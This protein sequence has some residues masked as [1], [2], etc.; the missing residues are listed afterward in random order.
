MGVYINFVS[1]VLFSYA[2]WPDTLG[3]L[4]VTPPKTCV[5]RKF[6]LK[7]MKA[8]QSYGKHS[9]KDRDR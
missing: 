8:A 2:E 5:Y 9:R 1:W 4:L 7:S 6:G 3:A